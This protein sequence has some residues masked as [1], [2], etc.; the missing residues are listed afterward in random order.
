MGSVLDTSEEMKARR[1]L[2]PS[3]QSSRVPGTYES[4]GLGK[5]TEQ[6]CTFI[7]GFRWFFSVVEIILYI[8][9]FRDLWYFLNCGKT[10]K[11]IFKHFKV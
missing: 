8:L 3:S 4:Q 10:H 6:H 1:T 9:L 11:I 7:L 5:D 2:V